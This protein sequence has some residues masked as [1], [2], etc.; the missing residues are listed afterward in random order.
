MLAGRAG[1]GQPVV[2]A[3]AHAYERWD[4]KGFPAGLEGDAI[5]LPVRVVV[6]ARDADLAASR[7]R[8]RAN[9]CAERSG[10]AY[11]P[12]VVEAF[13]RGRRRCP[14]ARPRTSGRACWR[15]SRSPSRPR[16]RRP[17]C[18]ARGVRR[19]RRPQV[20]VD[21]R[22]LSS[23]RVSRRAGRSACRAR[24][25]A[26]EELHRAGL[27]H[28]VGRVA[29]RTG[30]GTSRG[31]HDVGMGARAAPSYSPT[32]S[33]RGVTRSRPSRGSRRRTTS[34]STGP[35]ITARSPAMRCRART[36]CWP[37]RTSMLLSSRPAVPCC[38]PGGRSSAHAR[39]GRRP[40]RQAVACVLAAADQRPAPSPPRLAG[41]P[42]RSRGRGAAPD[43]AGP[44]EPRGRR[45]P[46][47]LAED[48]R[49]SRR[50][51]VREDR[52]VL[53]SRRGALRDGAR[54]LD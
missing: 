32:G 1:L 25:G 28:D 40:D 26:C 4:G 11:D 30:S 24:R 10:R 18:G 6:V 35:A 47:H 5:P 37:R 52:R 51:R 15:P 19:L 38:L 17:R 48:G 34:A 14:D 2:D 54:L 16:R 46:L 22:P 21:P 39:S 53:A 42:D 7:A 20:A 44:V 45:A 31:A 43:R 36:G 41:R 13:E 8:T 33:W 27:L 29:V 9:G 3:L 12:A 50:E 49:A 23:R